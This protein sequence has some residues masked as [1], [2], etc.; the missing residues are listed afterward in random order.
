MFSITSP[1]QKIKHP[2]FQVECYVCD[3]YF[4]LKDMQPWPVRLGTGA[5]ITY[6][7]C[8]DCHKSTLAGSD[9]QQ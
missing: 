2:H 3:R 5:L 4:W 8:N 1:T 7:I 9:G 6:H